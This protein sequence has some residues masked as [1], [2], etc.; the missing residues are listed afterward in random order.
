M[1]FHMKYHLSLIC[2][3]ILPSPLLT[4]S[5]HSTPQSPT[6]AAIVDDILV[7]GSTIP[8]H[9]QNMKAVLQRSTEKGVKL[10]PDKVT[11]R[12]TELSYF[13]NLLTAD[14][15]RPDPAKVAA[16][17][18]MPAPT[19]SAE[20]STV[21]GMA[22]YL[23]K[24]V[25]GLAE[26]TSPMRDLMKNNVEYVWD[27]QQDEAFQK[28]KVCITSAKSLAYFDSQKEVT[29]QVDAS[30]RGLEAT[31]MQEGKLIAYASKSLTRT[32]QNYAQIEKD[33]Y[34]IVFG[35][36]RFHHY[37]YGRTTT[38]ET[39]HKPLESIMKKPLPAAPPR[40]QRMMLRLQKYD[41]NVIY[42][43]GTKVPVADTLSR[44]FLKTSAC[45]DNSFN[46]QVH[47]VMMNLPI[48]DQKMEELK[49]ASNADTQLS[50]L[51][52]TI[53]NGWPSKRSQC[54]PSVTEFWNNRD[55]L[56]G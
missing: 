17:T 42:R 49:A 10:N 55:E 54:H 9:D 25:P 34:A 39:D 36:E 21:L 32:E 8:E 11:F 40:L 15:L 48:S 53:L 16:I 5:Y 30:Q 12:V 50:N 24:Y 3:E 51:K 31:L 7:Y 46:L 45:E 6:V 44:Q 26:I 52:T 38:V 1:V 27:K 18:D 14:G 19:D 13:G 37:I 22:N 28:M 43:P 23:A 20:L 35:C 29:V 56:T 33:M 47:T 4:L 2:N 41:I